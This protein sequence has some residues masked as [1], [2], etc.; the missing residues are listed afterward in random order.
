[1]KATDAYVPFLLFKTIFNFQNHEI[2]GIQISK[3]YQTTNIE[4]EISLIFIF[5]NMSRKI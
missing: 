4:K 1:M 5:E 2:S 3:K